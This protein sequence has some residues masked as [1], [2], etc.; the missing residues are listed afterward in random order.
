MRFFRTL[1][2]VLVAPLR[3]FAH[4]GKGAAAVEFALILP[5]MLTL[6]VGSIELSDLISVDRRVTVIAGTI[7]D[8]VARTNGDITQTTLTDYFTAAEEIIAPYSSTGLV[9]IVT[10]VY[11]NASGVATVEWSRSSSGSG[12]RATSSVYT[13]PTAITNISKSSYVIV[14]E[15]QYSYKSL[16]GMVIQAPISLYRENFYLPRYGKKINIT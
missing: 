6:Y 3:R 13:M 16:F 4:D 10:C 14:S 11:V 15:T 5:F 8:L 9:Q 7:G 12:A 2:L 1:Y